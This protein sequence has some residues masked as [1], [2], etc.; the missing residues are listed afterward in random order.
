MTIF[1][2]GVTDA[3]DCQR[4]LH[5]SD[6]DFSFRS[7]LFVMKAVVIQKDSFP[8]PCSYEFHCASMDGVPETLEDAFNYGLYIRD[9]QV[10]GNKTNKSLSKS[11]CE[12]DQTEPVG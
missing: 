6:L 9:S 1:G 12:L 3:D 2:A 5:G 11:T 8:V 4:C 10:I 7:D